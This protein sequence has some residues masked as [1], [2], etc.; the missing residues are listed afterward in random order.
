MSADPTFLVLHTLRIRGFVSVDAL[1]SA[2][3]SE[4]DVCVRT[5]ER[6]GEEGLA[7]HR[8]GH[9]SG[10]TLTPAG[11]DMHLS[12]LQRDRQRTNCVE[13][14]H[15]VYS[16]FVVRNSEFKQLCTDWQLRTGTGDGLIPNDHEDTEYDRAV[17]DRLV[18]FDRDNEPLLGQLGQALERL[19][20]Y[21]PRLS[22]AARA[23]AGGQLDRFTAPLSDSYHD[24]WMELHQDLIL[25]LGVERT[26]ADA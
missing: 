13:L 10:W 7:Y 18:A 5:L 25:T 11:R 14:L 26:A 4:S 6:L 9:I 19:S 22:A 1:T 17:I 24:I 3:T 8:Q 23:V 15:P 21:R 2:L 12:E 20:G 16:E